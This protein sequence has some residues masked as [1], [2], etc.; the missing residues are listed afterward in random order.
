MCGDS[1]LSS[2]LVCDSFC[3]TCI[4]QL[5]RERLVHLHAVR[6]AKTKL[7]RESNKPLFEGRVPYICF[8][9]LYICINNKLFVKTSCRYESFGDDFFIYS[10]SYSQVGS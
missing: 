3:V 10:V 7:G 5:L 6:T 2:S 9:V 4:K 8:C 1:M